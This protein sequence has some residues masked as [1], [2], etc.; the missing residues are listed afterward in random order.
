MPF[1]RPDP[2]ELGFY[3]SLAQVGLEMVVP[4]GLGVWLGNYFG[5][6]VWGAIV[7]ALLG[8]AAG[9]AHLLALLNRHER[10][11]RGDRKQDRP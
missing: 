11:D 3:Y 7:G 8:F 1:G 10:D 4:I 5:V 2:K 9:L 6:M